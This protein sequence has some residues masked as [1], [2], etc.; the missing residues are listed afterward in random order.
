MDAIKQKIKQSG[1]SSVHAQLIDSTIIEDDRKEN[2]KPAP[3]PAAEPVYVN[4]NDDVNV[5]VNVDEKPPADVEPPKERRPKFEDN[6]TRQ[7]VWIR[8]DLVEQIEKET[9]GERGEKAR[10]FNE[11]LEQY[12][13]KRKR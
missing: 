11:A 13:R 7:T 10:I 9:V 2:A 3:E 8:K 6:H 12:L 1:A 5:H 4:V